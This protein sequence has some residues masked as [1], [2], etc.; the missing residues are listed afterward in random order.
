MKLSI[1]QFSIIVI[2]K[3]MESHNKVTNPTLGCI[4]SQMREAFERRE[5]SWQGA[6][7]GGSWRCVVVASYGCVKDAMVMHYISAQ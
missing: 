5:A 7:V 2:S 4:F 3:N 1:I 6:V